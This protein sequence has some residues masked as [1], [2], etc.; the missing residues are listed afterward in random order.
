[1]RD[2]ENAAREAES[3]ARRAAAL[4]AETQRDAER[5]RSAADAAA[6][7]LNELRRNGPR[8]A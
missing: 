6:A 3:Q 2:L 8:G 5:A 7:E 1:L 4:A